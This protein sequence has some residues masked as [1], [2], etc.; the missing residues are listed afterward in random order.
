MEPG[1]LRPAILHPMDG[2]DDVRFYLSRLPFG[3]ASYPDCVVRA[4]IYEGLRQELPPFDTR[5]VSQALSP[6]MATY[7]RQGPGDDWIPEVWASV[8]LELWFATACERD[9]D[10]CRATLHEINAK[11]VEGALFRTVTRVLSPSLVI[12]GMARTWGIAR[13]GSSARA[14]MGPRQATPRT[15]EVALSH[16]AWVYSERQLVGFEEVFIVVSESMGIDDHRVERR[17]AEAEE[18]VFH[19]EWRDR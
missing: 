3:T 11:V 18:T 9:D 15:A 7:L 6:A 14:T 4:S 19:L 2:I 1:R 10:R 13:R 17:S 8:L 12:M 5:V 16:P